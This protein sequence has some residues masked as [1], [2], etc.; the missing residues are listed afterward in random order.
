MEL[1][2]VIHKGSCQ[3]ISLRESKAVS[4]CDLETDPSKESQ[5]KLSPI[6]IGFILK[7]VLKKCLNYCEITYHSAH[8]LLKDLI[9]QGC[10]GTGSLEVG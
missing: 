6:L 3:P 1:T 10:K 8:V 4:S 5:H 9:K 7:D 2:A